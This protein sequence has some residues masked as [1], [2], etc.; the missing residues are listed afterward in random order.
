MAKPARRP[1][2]TRPRPP[3]N[4]GGVPRRATVR[5]V[6]LSVYLPTFLAEIGIGAILP[7]FALSALSMGEAAAVASIAVAVYSAGRIAGSAVAGSVASHRGPIPATFGAYGVLACGALAC[8]AA[9]HV[10]VL[11]I[12]VAVIGMGHGG[13]HVARQAHIDALTP[14]AARA[15]ALTTLAGTWRVANFIG[16]FAGATLIAVWGLG[17]AYVFAAVTVASGVGVL[18]FTAPRRLTIPRAERVR[19]GVRE[20]LAPQR[21]VLSTLGVG[22]VLMGALR[23]ARMVVLPL[24]AAHIGM[25]DAGASLVFGVATAVDMAMFLP[26]GWVMDRYGRVWTA[27]PSAVALAVG[28]VLLPFSTRPWE[29]AAL[30]VVLGAGNGWGTGVIMTMGA[31]AAPEKGRPVF[32]GA[33]SL[34]QDVGGLLGPVLVA[35]GAAIALPVGLFAVG[36]VGVAATGAF[37]RWTPR[38]I[39]VPGQPA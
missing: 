11:A 27:V 34:L 36:G 13:V 10:A 24:W 26:A 19:L 15:R 37:V 8:A 14:V 35:A 17:A 12:G 5:D 33:W 3:L 28:A 9:S 2:S 39:P 31:D 6:A 25:S 32:L 21:R 20:V 29:V 16:P 18:V 22:V 23:Q 38:G 4:S 7:I 30:A 1:A